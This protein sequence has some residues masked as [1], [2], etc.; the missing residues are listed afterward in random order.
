[1]TTVFLV[2]PEAHTNGKAM[3]ETMILNHDPKYARC[4]TP[5]MI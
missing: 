4:E 2:T 1:M 3:D 5:I